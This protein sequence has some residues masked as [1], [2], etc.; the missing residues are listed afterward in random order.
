MSRK[1]MVGTS[2]GLVAI[3]DRSGNW[4]IDQVHFTGL[5]VSAFHADSVSGTWWTAID[6]RHWGTKVHYSTNG[7]SEWIEVPPPAFGDAE[8]RPGQRASLKSIWA[9]QKVGSEIWAGTEPAAVFTRGNS[10]RFELCESLWNYPGRKDPNQWFGAGRNAPFV[11]S[12]VV[13]PRDA[14]RVFIAVSA[15]GIFETTDGGRTWNAR[16]EGLVSHFLPNPDAKVGHDPHILLQCAEEPDVLWQQSH[17]G[18]FRSINA[19]QTWVEIEPAPAAPGYGFTMAIDHSDPARAWVIP[20]ASDDMRTAPG[21]ALKVYR[22]DDGGK[23]WSDS[24]AGLPTNFAFDIV[25]R[26]AFTRN[27]ALMVFGTNNGNVYMSENEGKW[28]SCFTSSLPKVNTID[29]VTN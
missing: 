14:Q 6:H 20:A 22:T 12:I 5:P 19:G 26:K 7:G 24:S 15:A 1:I 8:Y 18:I 10:G 13:D 17:S 4:A 21:L 28:W 3:S 11:H 9:L 29:I 27:K 2:K 25:L 16:N 23:S